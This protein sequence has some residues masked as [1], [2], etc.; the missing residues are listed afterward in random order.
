MVELPDA[1]NVRLI[2]NRLGDPHE[3]V[4]IDAAV[5][6]VFEEH[7]GYALLQWRCL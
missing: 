6:A 2:G 4:V 7:D 5:E 1:G 3:P